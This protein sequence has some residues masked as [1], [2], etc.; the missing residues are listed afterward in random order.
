[1]ITADTY[2]RP[3]TLLTSSCNQQQSLLDLQHVVVCVKYCPSTR[4]C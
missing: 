2:L 1:M 3:I 4:P